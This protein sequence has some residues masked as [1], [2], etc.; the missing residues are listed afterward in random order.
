M[1]FEV[2]HYKSI[3]K[4]HALEGSVCQDAVDSYQDEHIAI[5]AV[6][7]GHGSSQYFR[8]HLGSQFAVEGTIELLKT[9]YQV[10]PNYLDAQKHL[11]NLKLQI[12]VEWNNRV[13]MDYKQNPIKCEELHHLSEKQQQRINDNYFTAYGTT[14]LASLW[15]KQYLLVFRIGDGIIAKM[16]P[17]LEVKQ[18][19][20]DQEEQGGSLTDSM[21]QEDAYTRMQVE[22]VD[23]PNT[24]ALAICSDGVINGFGNL[25]K[26]NTYLFK[27]LLIERF[28][29][30]QASMA[31]ILNQAV[32][33][34]AGAFSS[35]DDSS[36][37]ISYV[38][39]T[40]SPSL[41]FYDCEKMRTLLELDNLDQ[42]DIDNQLK[43]YKTI[44]NDALLT[45]TAFIHNQEL[46]NPTE[47]QLRLYQT[48]VTSHQP[49]EALVKFT[50]QV[51][52]E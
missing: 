5:T 38:V 27:P 18:L 44:D 7:D 10:H 9:F 36:L 43:L 39:P 13:E 33:Q 47:R 6:A 20:V 23:N 8:S 45:F 22:I 21:C 29:Y 50:D 31:N 16:D 42:V 24:T 19:L 14:L 2:H 11:E 32:T 46:L 41:D 15:C 4:K 35:S 1:S 34:I 49:L 17:S 25:Y 48:L 12:L 52:K 28:R 3:G 40:T 30:D 26:F 37:A 51:I